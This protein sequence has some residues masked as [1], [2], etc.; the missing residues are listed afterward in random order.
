MDTTHIPS[1]M[2]SPGR[3]RGWKVGYSAG[4]DAA[5]AAIAKHDPETLRL[6]AKNVRRWKE[7][8]GR[9]WAMT[10]PPPVRQGAHAQK[11]IDTFARLAEQERLR[12]GAA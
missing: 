8:R 9:Q 3:D 5:L 10:P 6:W 4:V 7:F 12:G 11:T 1:S 2:Q